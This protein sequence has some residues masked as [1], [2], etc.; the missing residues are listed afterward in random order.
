METNSKPV[1]KMS[2]GLEKTDSTRLTS[3]SCLRTAG[4][5]AFLCGA[6]P[7]ADAG[8]SYAGRRKALRRFS[9]TIGWY[10]DSGLRCVPFAI[11]YIVFQ[12]VI[13]VIVKSTIIVKK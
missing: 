13:L 10:R 6:P 4:A 3:S 2:W 12:L 5:G 8:K 9:L 11:Y 7:P 1:S